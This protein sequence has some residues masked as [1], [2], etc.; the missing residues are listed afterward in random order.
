MIH[1]HDPSDV[2][3]CL[4]SLRSIGSEQLLR[5]FDGTL[6]HLKIIA[7]QT[8]FKAITGWSTCFLKL[9][10]PLFE[11]SSR[12]SFNNIGRAGIEYVQLTRLSKDNTLLTLA[13]VLFHGKK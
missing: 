1:V 7:S 12:R 5:A 3:V 10:S 4:I 6:K 9:K 13:V 8:R 2:Y 11:R